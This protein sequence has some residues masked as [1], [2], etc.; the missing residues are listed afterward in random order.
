MYLVDTNVLLRAQQPRSKQFSDA[1]LAV[2]TLQRRGEVLGIVPQ[3]IAEFWNVCTRPSNRNGLGL[4]LE[5]AEQKLRAIELA[6]T[7]F[8]GSELEIYQQWRELIITH[9]VKGVQVHDAK[10]VASMLVHGMTHVIT[11][12]GKDF[13]RFSN[14]KVVDPSSIATGS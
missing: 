2:E 1:L 13:Q 14:I 11:F 6:F 8:T 9:Q 4:S 7:L 10:L 12:N 3:V 5:V